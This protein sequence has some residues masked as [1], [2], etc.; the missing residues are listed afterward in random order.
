MADIF[1]P[2]KTIDD[3]NF[4]DYD[5]KKL[6]KAN[7]SASFRDGID[8]LN[9][10]RETLLIIQKLG[11]ISEIG[12]RNHYIEALRWLKGETALTNWYSVQQTP[13]LGVMTSDTAESFRLYCQQLKGSLETES[14]Y[15]Q[16]EIAARVAPIVKAIPITKRIEQTI[17]NANDVINASTSERITSIQ[18]VTNESENSIRNIIEQ[19]RLS[20][21]SSLQDSINNAYVEIDQRVLNAMSQV[22]QATALTDWGTVYDQDIT[23]LTKRLYGRSFD[24]TFS[25]NISSLYLKFKGLKSVGVK[26]IKWTRLLVKVL[27]LLIKNIFSLIRIFFSIIFSISGRRVIAF[28]L[29]SAGALGLTLLPILETIGIIHTHLFNPKNPTQWLTKAAI[30]IPLVVVLSIAY[31]FATKNYRIYS[32]M[33]DQYRHRRAVAKTAQGIIL[34]VDSSSG[35]TSIRDAM[36]AAAATA[37]FEHKVTGHLSKKEVSR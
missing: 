20:A 34:S 27:T 33:L 15:G 16:V 22:K 23:E 7:S 37:L 35:D 3:S 30:F 24:G 10:I 12:N 36:T 6:S 9:S 17:S 14:L 31:S 2:A 25:R 11:R 26:N 4:L 28:L 21:Q 29:L 19:A 18:N 32:N 1:D 5:I 13:D 8:T